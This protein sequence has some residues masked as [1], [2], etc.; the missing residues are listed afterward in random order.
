MHN[1]ILV[2]L[3][4]ALLC[5]CTHTTRTTDTPL[6]EELP[7]PSPLLAQIGAGWMAHMVCSSVFVSGRS[8][9]HVLEV[10][11]G[12]GSDPMLDVYTAIVDRRNNNVRVGWD[13]DTP[14][15]EM[16]TFADRVVKAIVTPVSR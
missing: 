3:S 10:E 4:L 11:F 12:P 5:A 13:F 16:E 14:P 6:P 8:K 7:P 9:D 2:T 1:K 15:W